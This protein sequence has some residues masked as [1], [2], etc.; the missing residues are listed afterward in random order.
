MYGS[1]LNELTEWKTTA[2]VI[3]IFSFPVTVRK[4]TGIEAYF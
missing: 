4:R 2:D 1:I 3:V